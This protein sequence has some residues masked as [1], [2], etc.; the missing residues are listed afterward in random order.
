MTSFDSDLISKRKD[1]ICGA[2]V[3]DFEP[4]TKFLACSSSQ[5]SSTSFEMSSALISGESLSV[6]AFK[7]LPKS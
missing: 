7:K 3:M 4:V 6:F 2:F 5:D 1:A